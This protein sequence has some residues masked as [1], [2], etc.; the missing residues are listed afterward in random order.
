MVMTDLKSKFL[1]WWNMMAGWIQ[2]H[3][4]LVLGG[5]VGVF[6]VISLS[7]LAFRWLQPKVVVSPDFQPFTSQQEFDD[8][9][10][11]HPLM[12]AEAPDGSSFEVSG[13]VTRDRRAEYTVKLFAPA[14]KPGNPA[15]TAAYIAALKQS[16]K[17]ALDWIKTQ[18]EPMD[19]LYVA[20][21]PN[22]DVLGAE[23]DRP[24]IPQKK[25]TAPASPTP[26]FPH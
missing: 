7:W 24:P 21:T 9:M 11:K 15:S 1:D 14:L 20:W 5:V 25:S 26:A 4:R 3:R 2:Q 23:T 18:G 19:T 8:F 12:K 16:Q 22:P 10:A 17:E 13:E 6:V